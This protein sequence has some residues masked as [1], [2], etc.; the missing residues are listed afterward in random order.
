MSCGRAPHAAKIVLTSASQV[1][2][3]SPAQVKLG[4]PVR[5]LGIVTYADR[6]SSDCFIQDSSGGVRV[7][8][9]SGQIPPAAGL[10]VEVSGVAAAGGSAPTILAAR[11]TVLDVARLPASVS[12]SPAQL[13]DAVYR[14]KRVAVPGVVQ[15]ISSDRPGLVSV[16]IGVQGATIRAK[17]PVSPALFNDQW[18]D[19]DVSANG[20][21]DEPVRG[22]SGAAEVT[23]WIAEPRAI[24]IRHPATAP[25]A[26]PV[27]KIHAASD[28][29]PGRIPTH[30]V[31]IQGIPY[32]PVQGGDALMDESGQILVRNRQNGIDANRPQLDVAG[33]LAFE[34]GHLI[35]DQATPV[36]AVVNGAVPGGPTLGST[37][38]AALQVRQL[39]PATA[40]LA[41]P[42]HLRAV[43]TF[44]DPENHLL[45][46]QDN[47]DAI[48]V[49][50]SDKERVTLRSGDL[51]DVQGVS[52]ADFAP[53]VDKA[54]IQV[55]GHSRLPDAAP[56]G[57]DRAIRGR[58][59]CHWIELGGIIQRVVNGHADTLLTV[60][61]GRDTYR[62]HVLAPAESL[63]SLVGAEVTLRGVCGALF[64]S[65][66]QMLGIQLFV[67]GKEFIRVVREPLLEPF[68]MAPTSIKDLMQFSYSTDFGQ[69]VR[70]RGTV[71]YGNR[72]G[73]T[74]IHD[75]TG[76]VMIRNHN[77]HDLAAGDLV[78]VVGFPA[79]AG[80]S[81]ILR[82]ALLKKLQSGAPPA[83]VRITAQDA[84][85]GG[86]DGQLVEIEGKLIDRV[87]QPAEQV[88]TVESGGTVFNAYLPNSGAPP[89][90]EAG[91]L[92]RLTGICA[93]DAEQSHDLILPRG[94]R[95]LLRSPSDAAMI[96][97]LPWLSAE[98][99]I[100]TAGGAVL[101]VLAALAW[102]V[103]LR[104]RVRTQTH[105]LRAQTM[106]LQA[107]HQRAR[108]ALQKAREAE[109]VD[110]D[111]KR[112]VEL[113]ARDEPVD[114]I[115]DR[116]AEAVA[117]HAEGAVCVV[118]LAS[119][120]GLRV[121]AVPTLPAG[122]LDALG[123]LEM[124]SIPFSPELRAPEKFAADPN[125]TRFIGSQP[126]ARFKA[127]CSAP[128]VV[129]SETVGLIAAFFRH[130]KQATDAQGEML[131]LWCNIAALALDRRRLHDQLSYRAQ[132][133]AL[134]GLPN[135]ALLYDRLEAE[136]AA[137]S[138]AGYLLGVL[139]ID[140][141]GFKTV[142]DTYGH[143]A[144]DTVLQHSARRMT[145]IMRRGDTV[146]RIGGDEFVVLLPRLARRE[147]AEQIAAKISSVLREPIYANH[148]RLAVAGS[149]GISIWPCDGVEADPLLRFADAQM[150][151]AKK[152]RWYDV[153]G[154]P[155]PAVPVE[156]LAK[157]NTPN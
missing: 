11:A 141:D 14:Y 103:L 81:P 111:S 152:R 57:F 147:D 54:R 99:L 36:S 135:R 59:D 75:A 60:A 52:T 88:L 92:L 37:L 90:L 129:E 20:V 104:R 89:N 44:F 96:S 30:R 115:I 124:S 73:A 116:I 51:V 97:S 118:L 43:V 123:R 107:A 121:C 55:L 120:Q 61:W 119:K 23:L 64:N 8:F 56:G 95:L 138:Q 79:I 132:H 5:M 66:Y 87:P 15:S 4:V 50:L 117:L 69:R 70:V 42:V 149:V 25:A 150:Y 40:R 26:L 29:G 9:A 153:A 13:A 157:T 65:R 101:V 91:A 35:L 7:R 32:K 24:Q 100:P 46:V 126:S 72:S 10:K 74:W 85:Q 93:V 47:T 106:Q 45:F 31:R 2:Q 82:D 41:Y 71:T 63:A 48:F 19:A 114:L 143:D 131:A 49:D 16:E 105:A 137:A 140:L 86:F 128:I 17:V 78:D 27:M 83:A 28:L 67:P 12:I 139:Y 112:I 68:A 110:E 134:T 22:T 146:A 133:D 94:F 144:G 62:A 6:L 58:L 145:Q 102:A 154:Q 148:Q 18:I 109:L 127:F 38:T 80:Y 1:R 156:V 3:L 155:P 125:W 21:L 98:R 34:Q 84:A 77:G 136:I 130:E 113:I 53:N 122:W 142:N 151:G 108:A 33:F 76:G 39:A